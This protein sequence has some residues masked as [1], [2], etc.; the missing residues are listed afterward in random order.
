MKAGAIVS[1]VLGVVFLA[2]SAFYGVFAVKNAGAAA[3]LQESIGDKA[4]FV[5]KLVEAKAAKQR[6]IALGAGIPALLLIGAGAVLLRR[7][8]PGTKSNAQFA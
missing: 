4:G 5:V 7:S 1:L 8:N 3:R 6:N 2:A